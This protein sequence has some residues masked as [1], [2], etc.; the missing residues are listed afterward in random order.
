MKSVQHFGD[1]ENYQAAVGSLTSCHKGLSPFLFPVAPLPSPHSVDVA[2]LKDAAHL[3]TSWL[4]D[5]QQCATVLVSGAYAG[6]H[7][8]TKRSYLI[9]KW[10]SWKLLRDGRPV[11]LALPQYAG[12]SKHSVSEFA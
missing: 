9:S 3:R 1:A 11:A 12:A 10:A 6:M 8:H 7:Y 4:G 2:T 5:V